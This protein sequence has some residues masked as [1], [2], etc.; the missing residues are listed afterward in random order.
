M[1]IKR[2]VNAQKRRRA[3]LKQTKGFWG[4]RS[5]QYRVARQ[6]VMRSLV[7]AYKGR[8]LKKRNF[9]SL[10]ITRISAACKLNDISYNRFIYGLKKAD[11]DLNRKMLADIAVK[12]ENAFSQIVKAAKAA[13]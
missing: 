9:R 5:K 3:V 10:W 12:D 4:A 6:A 1:R 8:K 13:L 2:A 7:Y 11:I